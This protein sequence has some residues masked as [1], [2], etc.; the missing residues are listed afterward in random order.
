MFFL[1]NGRYTPGVIPPLGTTHLSGCPLAPLFLDTREMCS[2]ESLG[3]DARWLSVSSVRNVMQ[4]LTRS[5]GHST[6]GNKDWT[7]F[8]PKLTACLL[9]Q[10]KFCHCWRNQENLQICSVNFNTKRR[11]PLRV[12]SKFY[13]HQGIT[14]L[15]G[16]ENDSSFNGEWKKNTCNEVS[17][18]SLS[19]L[20]RSEWNC[21]CMLS[22]EHCSWQRSHWTVQAPNV[23]CNKNPTP[24]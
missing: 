23:I 12:V 13:T 11:Q 16:R 10:F 15:C 1:G 24:T 4:N 20:R 2:N 19:S 21:V 6:A 8:S 7:D 14:M 22:T 3:S 5:P 9:L 18:C 17:R